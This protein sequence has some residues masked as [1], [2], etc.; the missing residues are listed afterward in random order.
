MGHSMKGLL[1]LIIPNRRTVKRIDN[2]KIFGR[3]NILH[4]FVVE[5]SNDENDF[6]QDLTSVLFKHFEALIH[7]NDIHLSPQRAD[8]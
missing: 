3:L 7:A 8:I 4:S 6:M 2:K 5:L 1:L